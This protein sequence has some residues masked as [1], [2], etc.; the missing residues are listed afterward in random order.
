MTGFLVKSFGK[1]CGSRCW[2]SPVTGC[3]VTVFLLVSLCPSRE[4]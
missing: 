3:Q 2:R 1:R 4:S